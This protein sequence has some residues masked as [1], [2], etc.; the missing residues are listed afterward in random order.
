MII[1]RLRFGADE[2]DF[3][4]LFLDLPDGDDPAPMLWN[5]AGRLWFFWGLNKLDSGYPFQWIT[6]DDHGATWSP[7]RFPVFVTEIGGYSAQPITNA[8]RDNAGT[9]HVGN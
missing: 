4:S 3:P 5:D 2:W 7:V 6:S 8:F 1:T 9:I